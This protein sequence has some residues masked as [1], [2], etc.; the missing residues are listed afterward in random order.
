MQLE[1]ITKT[2]I[3]SF[4]SFL[5]WAVESGDLLLAKKL[6][7][8]IKYLLLKLEEYD[9]VVVKG[10]LSFPRVDEGY[11]SPEQIKEELKNLEVGYEKWKTE[12]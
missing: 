5:N 10:N 6:A 1:E 8:S 2:N 3:K 11:E 7:D 4:S 9:E 12:V